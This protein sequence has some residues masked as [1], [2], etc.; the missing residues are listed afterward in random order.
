MTKKSSSVSLTAGALFAA[1]EECLLGAD[2]SEVQ[3][4]KSLSGAKL[5]ENSYNIVMLV[6]FDTWADLANSWLDYQETMAETMSLFLSRAEMKR[7]DGYLVLLTP[8]PVPL[9]QIKV[10]NGIRSNTSLL[11][12]IL[13]TGDD[14]RAL[15]GVR[16]ALLPLLPM[17]V[18]VECSGEDSGL[19]ALPSILEK[20]GIPRGATN[21]IIEAFKEKKPI[22]QRL[23]EFYYHDEN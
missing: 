13:G 3:S 22:L 10:A 1:A 16:E 5:F 4:S 15:S 17:T 20:R 11:R 6:A 14:I 19:A 18:S 9:D 23:H 8:G 21:A 12:K 2:Y 7:W